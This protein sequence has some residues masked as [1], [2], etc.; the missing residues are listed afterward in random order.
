MNESNCL[1]SKSVSSSLV[2]GLV[3]VAAVA[4]IVGVPTSKA[5]AAWSDFLPVQSVYMRP[6][7]SS[8]EPILQISVAGTWSSGGCAT[9]TVLRQ[10]DDRIQ[11]HLVSMAM[12][13]F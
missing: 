12:S 8:G 3:A 7:P 1:R 4:A 6:A 10:G 11:D 2:R 13:A 9:N 5:F